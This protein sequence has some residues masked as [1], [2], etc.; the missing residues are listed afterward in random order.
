[1]ETSPSSIK[2]DFRSAKAWLFR[3]LNLA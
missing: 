3:E 1:M 2:R